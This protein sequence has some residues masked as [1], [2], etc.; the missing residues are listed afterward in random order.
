MMEVHVE[1]Q[2][3]I[4]SETGHNPKGLGTL[5]YGL[6]PCTPL[7]LWAAVDLRSSLYSPMIA[8][9]D[10]T[11]CPGF[12]ISANILADETLVQSHLPLSQYRTRSTEATC[13][14]TTTLSSSLQPLQQGLLLLSTTN[15]F[16]SRF[17]RKKEA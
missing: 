8:P 17:C 16:Q 7:W 15:A 12:R 5:E 6:D 11:W 1:L 10:S 3:R 9:H 14:T 4:G 2:A 13:I